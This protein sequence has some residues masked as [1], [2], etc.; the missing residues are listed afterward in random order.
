MKFKYTFIYRARFFNKVIHIT[1][2]VSKLL[3]AEYN[4]GVRRKY[5]LR[6]DLIKARKEEDH[7]KR[8]A[9]DNETTEVVHKA[10]EKVKAE[11]HISEKKATCRETDVRRRHKCEPL[12]ASK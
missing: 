2:N 9:Y 3:S 6:E 4:F 5:S 7:P 11:L 1:E 12:E 8:I 10:N